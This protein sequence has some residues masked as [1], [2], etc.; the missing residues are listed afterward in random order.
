MKIASLLFGW[1]VFTV[2]LAQRDEKEIQF[3]QLAIDEFATRY[4]TIPEK[5]FSNLLS[6]SIEGSFRQGSAVNSGQK[7]LSITVEQLS[8]APS[9]NNNQTTTSSRLMSPDI[10]KIPIVQSDLIDV[11]APVIK[12]KVFE[13][14]TLSKKSEND[15]IRLKFQ[16]NSNVG[17]ALKLGYDVWPVDMH[18][19]VLCAIS[20]LILLYVL[21]IFEV[22]KV[23]V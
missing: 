4:F 22:R 9:N 10:W 21:I 8:I 23:G 12:R 3:K 19:G 14:D 5:S 13:I 2:F 15:L 1:I 20:V 11:V 18:I 7:F 6:L 17:F 16:T